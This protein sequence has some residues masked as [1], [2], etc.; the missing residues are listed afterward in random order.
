[1]AIDSPLMEAGGVKGAK[2]VLINIT[3]S[4]NLGIHEVNEA[5]SLIRLA[6]ANDDVQ[7]NFGVVLDESLDDEVK[8][9]VIATG[10]QRELP[11]PEFVRP[12]ATH[13]EVT[14][15]IIAPLVFD[16]PPVRETPAP[17][18]EEPVYQEPVYQEPVA[19]A[20]A[21]PQPEPVR[22][23]PPPFDDLEV[24]AVLRRNRPMF[25]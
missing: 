15:P 25:Q 3:A 11:K 18:I 21:V 10:F 2:G 22:E 6:T 5:C 20:A 12:A 8:I 13:T 16:P 14:A 24:P 7:I 23:A 4:S 19:M 17:V 1:M 9:T